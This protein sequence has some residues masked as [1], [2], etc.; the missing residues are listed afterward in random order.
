[1]FDKA[2]GKGRSTYRPKTFDEMVRHAV[3][4]L[5]FAMKDGHTR[6]EIEFPPLPGNVDGYKGA[7][8]AFIDSNCQLAIAGARILSKVIF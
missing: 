8:D 6:L 3:E 1:M 7:S 4:S 5:E 2:S